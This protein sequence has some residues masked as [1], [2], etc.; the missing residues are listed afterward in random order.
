MNIESLLKRSDL[1][2]MGLFL[3]HGSEWLVET[4]KDKYTNRL[5]ES[6]IRIQD[7]FD[8]CFPDF[9]K[10]EEAVQLFDR[11]ASTYKDVYFE[12]GLLVGAKIEYEIH[13]RMNEIG[14]E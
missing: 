14:F 12:I 5:R 9:D 7:F 3:R 1:T 13:R 6:E 11:E 10:N 2:M 8:K 4:S